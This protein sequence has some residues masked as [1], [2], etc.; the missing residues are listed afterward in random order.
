V[1]NNIVIDERAILRQNPGNFGKG[2]QMPAGLP[3]F[4]TSYAHLE[5]ALVEMHGIAPADVPAFRSRFGALQRAGLL[6]AESQPGKGRRL[7]YGPDQFH[8]C[9]LA[10]EL[11]QAGAGPSVILR[12]IADHWTSRLRGIFER[13][14]RGNIRETSDV[15][16]IF[17]GLAMGFGDEPIPS[18]NDVSTDK[19]PERLSFALDG[20]SL[21]TRVLLVNISERL[22]RFHA[23]LINHHLR[24]QILAELQ[25]K[26]KRKQAAKRR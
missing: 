4:T 7:E 18:I 12:L 14:E 24:P 25:A 9:L 10:F 8:R 13:A 1:K 26:P 22:R 15:I 19:L 21:P 17:G 11:A 6:G 5:A 20:K 16:L 23:A 2:P 3:T